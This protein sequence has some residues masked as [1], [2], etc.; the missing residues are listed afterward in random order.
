MGDLDLAYSLAQELASIE[1]EDM[2]GWTKQMPAFILN[3]KGDKETAYAM[4]IELLKSSAQD[5]H[6]NEVNF[7]R[8]YI[9]TRILEPSKAQANPICQDIP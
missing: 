7:T 4:L 8:D 3:A 9:C 2:P 5:M 1:K 6:P